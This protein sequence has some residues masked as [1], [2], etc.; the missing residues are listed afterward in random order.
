MNPFDSLSNQNCQE[1]TSKFGGSNSYFS[2]GG[3][4]SMGEALKRGMVLV[5]SL[6]D[7]YGT[8]MKWMD[9][10]FP[11]GAD[12]NQPGVAKGPCSP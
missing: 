10:V 7:D 12:P 2:V 1:Q 6:W 5:M 3:T 4:K 9:G 11:P 8:H